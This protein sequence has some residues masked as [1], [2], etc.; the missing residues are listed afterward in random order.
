MDQS[1]AG[2]SPTTQDNRIIASIAHASILIPNISVIFPLIIW[3]SQ[4]EK[5]RFV[6]FQALQSLVY[7]FILLIGWY[8]TI[9]CS[10]LLI[11]IMGFTNTGFDT[12]SPGSELAILLPFLG[13]SFI[14][15]IS[16]GF[17][18][19]GVIAAVLTLQGQNFRYFLIGDW[20]LR[21]MNQA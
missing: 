10:I 9:A 17:V 8:A 20:L 5:S 6:A 13:I 12:S 7:Q 16:L 1:D 18:I 3:L 21:T 2:S 14:L 15:L 19:Y 11:F 4:K